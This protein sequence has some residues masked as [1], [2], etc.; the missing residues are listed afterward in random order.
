MVK[1]SELEVCW[2]FSLSVDRKLFTTDNIFLNQEDYQNPTDFAKDMNRVFP[3][4]LGLL[5]TL[6]TLQFFNAVASTSMLQ[7][8]LLLIHTG[9]FGYH[10][11]L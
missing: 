7:L 10:V 9:Y 5:G 4:E 8:I 1:F 3:Y 2:K 11:K 6:F